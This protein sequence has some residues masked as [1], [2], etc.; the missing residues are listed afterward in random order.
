MK[1]ENGGERGR[2]EPVD[3]GLFQAYTPLSRF[4]WLYNWDGGIHGKSG[5][6]P[7]LPSQL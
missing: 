4:S 2:D 3:A 1:I 5:E 7:A 6:T